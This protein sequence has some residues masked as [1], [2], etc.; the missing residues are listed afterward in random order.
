MPPLLP[1][2]QIHRDF[3]K[4]FQSGFQMFQDFFV[5]LLFNQG[6]KMI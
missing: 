1:V 2:M 3:R 4:L 6:L 5:S